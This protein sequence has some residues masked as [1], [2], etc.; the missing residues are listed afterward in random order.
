[1]AHTVGAPGVAGPACGQSARRRP[2]PDLPQGSPPAQPEALRWRGHNVPIGANRTAAVTELHSHRMP[3]GGNAVSWRRQG[4]IRRA[5]PRREGAA[6]ARQPVMG[7][8]W[9]LPLATVSALVVLVGAAGTTTAAAAPSTTLFVSASGTDVGN[10][11]CSEAAPCATVAHALGLAVNGDTISVGAGSF[12]GV[13]TVS[14]NVTIE[15]AGAN[16]TT[17]TGGTI[18]TPILTIAPDTSVSIQDLALAPT[19]AGEDGVLASSGTLGLVGVSITS[20][21]A[22]ILANGI[23]VSTG[24]GTIQLSV[25]DSTIAGA[26]QNGIGV[27]SS[28]TSANTLSVINSTIADNTADGILDTH[29]DQITLQEDTISGNSVGLGAPQAKAALTNT[30]LAGNSTADCVVAP[31]SGSEN[32]LIGVDNAGSNS[33]CA[34]LAGVDGNVV[35]TTTDPVKADLGP[36][37]NNGGPTQT[38]ALE[39]GSPAIGAGNPTACAAAPVNDLDQRGDPRNA[40]AR[41]TCDIGA[42]DTGGTETSSIPVGSFG[43]LGVAALLGGG[44]LLVQGSR[45][46]R[47][48]PTTPA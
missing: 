39:P 20:S 33:S 38:M 46:R 13:A 3:R 10:V 30:V 34:S 7:R 19:A 15:G 40:P 11:T 17:L 2:S 48:Q 8:P 21:A 43:G 9:L 24:A 42:Y 35:G 6:P 4:F 29:E 31:L 5:K 32:N 27:G 36:L 44:L 18:S 23:A 16:Q 1:M 28:S 41:G 14:V 25:L 22:S 45:R 47:R 12:P 37:G 26:L